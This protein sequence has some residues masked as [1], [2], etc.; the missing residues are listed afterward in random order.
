MKL[1]EIR[2]GMHV[3][4]NGDYPH[5]ARENC[6]GVG[7]LGVVSKLPEPEGYGNFV[8]LSGIPAPGTQPFLAWPHELDAVES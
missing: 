6:G 1:E 8:E 5:N 3:R 4:V 7:S 2:V